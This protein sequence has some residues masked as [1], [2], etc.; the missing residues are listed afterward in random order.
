LVKW[1]GEKGW[2]FV[3]RG[4]INADPK[5]LLDSQIGPNEIH[6]YESRNH[7]RDF[8]DRVISRGEPVAPIEVAHR[9]VT[10]AHLGN[11]AM[12]LGRKVKWDPEKECFPN[13]PE[14][15]RMTDRAMREPWVL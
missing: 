13:D 2:I 8:I 15:Q 9:S 4:G 12:M 11:I 1:I 6:L 10:C 14:A 3:K 7:M 5:S